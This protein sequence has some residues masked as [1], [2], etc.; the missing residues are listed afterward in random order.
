MHTAQAGEA[1]L[2][3][4]RRHYVTNPRR[5]SEMIYFVHGPDRW[6]A[7]AA[8]LEVAAQIDPTCAN[9]TWIEGRETTIESI[10]HAVVTVSFFGE[11]RVVIVTDFLRN[12]P[13][14]A[15]GS[16]ESDPPDRKNGKRDSLKTLLTAVPSDLCL[17]LFEPSLKAPPAV[18]RTFVPPITI[19]GA[20]PPRGMA[21]IAWLVAAAERASSQIDRRSAQL[22]A[23]TLYPQTWNRKPNNPRFDR[24][25]EMALLAQEIE[26]LA[27]AAHP[28]PISA[29]YVE[30][31]VER[32]PDHRVFRFQDAV[33]GGNLHSA[34]AELE[35]LNEASEEPAMIL[36]QLLGQLELSAVVCAANGQDAAEIADDLG[37]VSPARVSAAMAAPKRGNPQVIATM[38][39]A[40]GIDRDLKTGRISRP[41]EALDALVLT[42]T[43]GSDK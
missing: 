16:A 41:A 42:L 28:K 38:L 27:L 26:K 13:D 33:L 40:V 3:A 12:S 24:P 21:L 9:T 34:I 35:R 6:L 15:M 39:S 31:M 29:L 8:V 30:Q 5:E 2:R 25:P 22:L 10:V 32:G 18:I 37:G 14:D 11:T 43:V 36:N 17:I 4:S 23:E 19:L 20:E 1:G 7:R